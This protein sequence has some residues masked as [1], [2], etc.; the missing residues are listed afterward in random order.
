MRK[1]KIGQ[2]GLL[3][4]VII[5]FGSLVVPKILVRADDSTGYVTVLDIPQPSLLQ[6]FTDYATYPN[7]TGLTPYDEQVLNFTITDDD[8]LSDL[9]W[10]RIVVWDDAKANFGDS[11]NDTKLCQ[12]FWVESTDTWN[13]TDDGSSTWSIDT[14]NCSDPGSSSALTTYEF[15]LVFTPGKVA[16]KETSNNWKFNVTAMDDNSLEGYNATIITTGW[17]GTCQWYQELSFTTGSINFTLEGTAPG[18][19]NV[20]IENVDGSPATYMTFNIIANG[21][22]DIN[23]SCTDW[24]GP[25]TID[26]DATPIEWVNDDGSWDDG[27]TQPINTTSSMFWDGSV[28]GHDNTLEAGEDR[29]IYLKLACPGDAVGGDY[30]Q[31]ATFIGI[32]G[33]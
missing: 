28:L 30:T 15:Q 22:W 1:R 8:Q 10:V 4:C 21:V 26:V 23:G 32:D 7:A 17:A 3:I 31:T 29:N 18:W 5:L 27:F 19:G 33:S 20:T 14:G 9:N 24:T 6:V 12:F 2:M 13:M 11:S 25:G 16:Y